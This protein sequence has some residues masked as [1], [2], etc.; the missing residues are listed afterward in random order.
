MPREAAM[1][2]AVREAEQNAIIQFCNLPTEQTKRCL[3]LKQF[4]KMMLKNQPEQ[5]FNFLDR[6]YV[7]EFNSADVMR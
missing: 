1:K 5:S 7:E 3:I 4:E 2:Q 6:N